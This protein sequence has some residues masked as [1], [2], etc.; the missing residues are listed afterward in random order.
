MGYGYVGSSGGYIYIYPNPTSPRY[1]P[2]SF[3]LPAQLAEFRLA[4]VQPGGN[5]DGKNGNFLELGARVHRFGGIADG[6]KPGVFDTWHWYCK[7]FAVIIFSLLEIARNLR[8]LPF[9]ANGGVSFPWF[10][11]G[12]GASKP[13]MHWMRFHWFLGSLSIGCWG[14]GKKHAIRWNKNHVA[15]FISF[16]PH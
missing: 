4:R 8:N 16:L 11:G 6:S 7:C 3:V 12:N 5:S 9:L 13:E 2:L 10:F 15:H 14:C 1:L